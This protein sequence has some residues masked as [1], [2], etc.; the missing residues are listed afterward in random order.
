MSRYGTIVDSRDT[1]NCSR[2][3]PGV[4][5]IYQ[6]RESPSPA[7]TLVSTRST[8]DGTMRRYTRTEC[9]RGGENSGKARRATDAT[10]A[11]Q[12]ERLRAA[13]KTW[14]EVG[15]AMGCSH[16]T[17]LRLLSRFQARIRASQCPNLHLREGGLRQSDRSTLAWRTGR[18][19]ARRIRRDVAAWA[20]RPRSPARRAYRRVYRTLGGRR[21]WY[22]KAV[23]RVVRE[24]KVRAVHRGLPG[25]PV[26]ADAP[27]VRQ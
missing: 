11:I 15:A 9:R 13:G 26:P 14:R 10:R 6:S 22:F 17:A 8:G 20:A 21:C 2:T 5:R 18:L 1:G 3:A 7:A 4:K 16:T 27:S 12:I 25:K 19:T 23:R 24:L